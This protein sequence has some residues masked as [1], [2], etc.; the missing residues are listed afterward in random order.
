MGQ[1]NTII[2]PQRATSN[3]GFARVE[4]IIT[5]QEIKEQFLWGIKLTAPDGSEMPDAVLARHHR[6]AISRLEHKLNVTITPTVYVE[7]LDYRA[8]D[9]DAWMFL[10]LRHKPISPNPE[11]IKVEVQYIKDQV[12]IELPKAWYRIYSEPGHIQMTPTTGTF[13]QFFVSQTG[14]IL[15]GVWGSK[16]DYPSLYKVTYLAGFEQNKIPAIINQ[17][18]GYATAA[19]A[20]RQLADVVLGAPGLGGYS[21]GLDG[22]SQSLSKD[23]FR[24]RIEAYEEKVTEL[25][26]ELIQYYNSFTFA[27]L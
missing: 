20:L 18:I 16:K 15:P 21:I 10:Q 12:L 13:G 27:T 19:E 25:S 8:E 1:D 9:Y 17:W 26:N 11:D 7:D 22:L 2:Y 14:V 3:P 4:T 23:G 5:P 24:D 6:G